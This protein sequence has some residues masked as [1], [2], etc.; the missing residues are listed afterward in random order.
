MRTHLLAVFSFVSLFQSCRR[1]NYDDDSGTTLSSF[2]LLFIVALIF[3]IVIKAATTQLTIT[4]H[5]SHHFADLQMSSQEFYAS[6]E[7]SIA[8]LQIPDL[9]ISRTTYAEEGVLS[10][11][12]EYLRVSRKD[13]LFDICAAPLGKGYFV[14]W[15][16]TEQENFGKSLLGAIPFI[17]KTLDR[18]FFPLTYYRIDTEAMFKGFIHAHVLTAVDAILAQKGLRGLTEEQRKPI[19]PRR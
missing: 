2:L 18:H 19:D 6:L 17:G 8:E 13:L 12:R 4:A 7:K 3:Y 16:Q 15:W 11:N 5:W 1:R 14:S 9:S 10:S